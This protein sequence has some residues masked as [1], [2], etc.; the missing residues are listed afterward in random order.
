[1]E[2]SVKLVEYTQELLKAIESLSRG[3]KSDAELWLNN[4]YF[5]KGRARQNHYIRILQWTLENE[6]YQQAHPNVKGNIAKILYN[7]DTSANSEANAVF[8]KRTKNG[9][10]IEQKSSS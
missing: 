4:F 9:Y 1:M 5:K 2:V 10:V 8:V 6:H 3:S 7:I